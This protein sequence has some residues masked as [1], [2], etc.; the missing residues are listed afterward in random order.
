MAWSASVVRRAL[1]PRPRRRQQPAR[2][3][4]QRNPYRDVHFADPNV[5]ENDY[6][7]MRRS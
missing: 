7:R 5:V 2:L 3:R 6:W 4:D 1:I